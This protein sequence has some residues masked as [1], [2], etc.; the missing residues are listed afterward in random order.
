[1]AV[2]RPRAT[3]SHLEL[4]PQRAELGLELRLRLE[5]GLESTPRAHR[6]VGPL[7]PLE[8]RGGHP[9]RACRL[10]L[11]LHGLGAALRLQQLELLGGLLRRALVSLE[12][13][14]QRLLLGH[15]ILGEASLVLGVQRAQRRVLRLQGWGRGYRARVGVRAGARVRAGASAV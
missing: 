3:A 11:G 10:Q 9:L 6:L 5:L 8:L 4:V 12:P 13:Q 1:M 14:P 15:A 2:R 7:A